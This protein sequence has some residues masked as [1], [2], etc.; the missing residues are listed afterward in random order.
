MDCPVA[1]SIN[2]AIPPRASADFF[3]FFGKKSHNRSAH[4]ADV[5][6][7]LYRGQKVAI[8]TLKDVKGDAVNQFLLEADTMTCVCVCVCVCVRVF[9]CSCVLLSC[10][11]LLMVEGGCGIR[12][13]CSSSAS[14]RKAAPS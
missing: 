3:F 1:S 14:A 6:E 7:G 9:V 5:Y 12:T 11:L 8:K 13:W 10:A 2:A 4:R